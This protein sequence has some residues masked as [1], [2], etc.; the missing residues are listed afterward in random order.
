MASSQHTVDAILEQA[1]GAGA[2][3]AKKMF[4]EYGL[5]LDGKMVALVC[6]DRLLVKPTHVGRSQIG[7]VREEAPYPCAKPCFV[8][9][10]ERWDE[11]DWLAELFRVTAAGLPMPRRSRGSDRNDAQP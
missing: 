5:F 10:G 11:A 1:A 9:H 8:V 6:D 3:T 2:V 4:G 7:A